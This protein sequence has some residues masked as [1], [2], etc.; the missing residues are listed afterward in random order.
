MAA[1]RWKRDSTHGN[2][3]RKC[4]EVAQH[5]KSQAIV[6]GAVASTWTE[7]DHAATMTRPKA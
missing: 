2:T 4:N 3:C 1:R 6:T 7:G 5:A